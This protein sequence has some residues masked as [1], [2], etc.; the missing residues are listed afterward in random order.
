MEM[1]VIRL[2][3]GETVLCDFCGKDYTHD[4]TSLGG[5]LF[6]G[7]AV[8]PEC[9]PDFMKGV[10]KYGEEKYIKMQAEEGE[11]FCNFVYRVRKTLYA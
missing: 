7:H 9:L 8:C 11:T 2:Q 1:T 4:T 3:P 6:T 5:I 10:K